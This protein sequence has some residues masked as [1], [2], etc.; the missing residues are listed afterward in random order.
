[1]RFTLPTPARLA[2]QLLARLVGRAGSVTPMLAATL[3]L[4]LGAL[5]IQPAAAQAV[6]GDVLGAADRLGLEVRQGKLVRLDRPAASVFVADPDIADVQ[7]HSASLVYVFG[8]RAGVTTLFAVDGDENLLF[9]S[10]V[11]VEHPVTR[12]RQVISSL[13]LAASVDVQSIDGGVLLTGD[14]ADPATAEDLRELVT[15]F[16][17]E[18]EVVLNR[19]S[20]RAPTQV[21]LRV[22]VAEMSRDVTKIFGISW[23]NALAFGDFALGLSTG[24]PFAAANTVSGSFENDNLTI[25]GVIDALERE[26]LVTVLAEPNLT[27][28]SGE[29][30]SFL[31]GGEFPVPVGTENNDIQ[32]E[33]KQFGVSLS[34]TPTVLSRNRIGL[35]VRPEVSDLSENGAITLQNIVIPALATRRAETTVE[36]GSGQSFAIGGLISNSTRNSLEKVPGIGDLPI[37]GTLFRSTSFRQ[38]ETE[39]VIIVTP[40]LVEPRTEREFAVPTD[41][42]RPPTQLELIFDGRLAGS[43]PKPGPTARSAA[44]DGLRLAGPAGF[45]ID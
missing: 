21:N 11:T 25:D 19:L 9:S 38:R 41:G 18:N 28:L 42:F 1:M 45:V 33:F 13:G 10:V 31:A 24:R 35:R 20:I 4:T 43:Y 16:V 12:M 6:G 2:A 5:S 26:G 7:A 29:T 23:D 8:R 34:F 37:L 27:A 39:L 30:A 14:V 3:A 32:I 40:Y 15:Q 44:V 36:L 22:R 17:G